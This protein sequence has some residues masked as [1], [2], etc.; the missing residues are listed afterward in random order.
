MQ[1]DTLKPFIDIAK[2]MKRTYDWFLIT[3]KLYR[4]FYVALKFI[5]VFYD[6]VALKCLFNQSLS[7]T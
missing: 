7:I 5:V 4:Q 2:L 6:F 1:L 3:F